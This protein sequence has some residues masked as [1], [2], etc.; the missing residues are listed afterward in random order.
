MNKNTTPAIMYMGFLNHEQI[1][2]VMNI[3]NSKDYL[4]KQRADIVLDKIRIHRVIKKRQYH[5]QD[6]DFETHFDKT[7]FNEYLKSLD[8]LDNENIEGIAYGYIFCDDPNGRIIKTDYGNIVTVSESLKYF[9]YFMN[10]CIL[11]FDNIE[12]PDDVRHASLLIAIRTML[13]TESL[14]FELDPRGIIPDELEKQLI[15][16]TNL[17][18]EFIVGHEFSHHLLNHLDNASVIEKSMFERDCDIYEKVYT[19]EQQQE[20]EADLDAIK[21]PIMSDEMRKNFANRALFFFAYI[22][23][24]DNVKEQIFPSMNR[25]KNH[26]EPR[27]RFQKI[28]QEFYDLFEEDELENLNS[29]LSFVDFYKKELQEDVSTNIERYEFYGSVYLGSWRGKPLIDRVDY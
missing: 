27:E 24:Y 9:L 18:L 22:E 12:V 20:F 5:S 23:I 25:V 7:P 4:L 11:T 2:R 6:W 19:Y 17:Q 3:Q 16:Y 28:K 21:R 15:E 14:D 29:L 8:Y 26:P 10:L 13:Q 1:S